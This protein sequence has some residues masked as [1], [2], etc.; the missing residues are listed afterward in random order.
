[1]ETYQ[2]QLN[3]N[4]PRQLLYSVKQD[5]SMLDDCLIL[6][7]LGVWSVGLHDAPNFVYFAMEATS[8][9]VS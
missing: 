4:N 2:A 9:N 6:P 7:V 3:I 5:V 8:S 1:M